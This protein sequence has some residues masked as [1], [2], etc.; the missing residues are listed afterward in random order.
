MNPYLALF[1]F[2][3]KKNEKSLKSTKMRNNIVP[4]LLISLLLISSPVTL[5][6]TLTYAQEVHV[7]ADLETILNDT[8]GFTNISPSTL[9]TFPAGKYQAILYAEL[10]GY[11]DTN[12][13]R[14]YPVL[15][16]DFQ[17]IFPGPVGPRRRQAAKT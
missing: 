5:F 14:Y 8:L 15:T 4:F 3:K 16:D 2:N 11:S 9:E 7:E 10:A 13:L 12:V 1:R 6:S 17:T